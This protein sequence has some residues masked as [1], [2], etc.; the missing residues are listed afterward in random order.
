[1]ASLASISQLVPFMGSCAVAQL[2]LMLSE[3]MGSSKMTFQTTFFGLILI[4]S[5]LTLVQTEVRTCDVIVCFHHM[6]RLGAS[7]A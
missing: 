7:C 4:M 1:M 3:G 5:M 2:I 6:L